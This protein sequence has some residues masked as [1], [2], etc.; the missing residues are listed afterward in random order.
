LISGPR[1]DEVAVEIKRRKHMAR[2]WTRY[3]AVVCVAF[4]LLVGDAQATSMSAD[5]N[6]VDLIRHAEA[7]VMAHVEDVN[8]GFDQNG[9]PHTEVTLAITENIHGDLP[10]HYVFRQYGL[11]QKRLSEDGTKIFMPA[12]ALFPRYSPGEQVMLFLYKPASRT[13]LQTTVALAHG[14]FTIG[15]TRATNA[16]GNTGLFQG[17]GLTT[18]L[19]TPDFA[20]MLDTLTGGV[21]SATLTSFVRR[22]VEEKWI[23]RGFMWKESERR[24]VEDL[25]VPDSDNTHGNVHFSSD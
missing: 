9:M 25:S 22:A 21:S 13:G 11:T 14:K 18:E 5:V 2:R 17:V 16:L 6:L 20:A 10:Q 7:I 3:A 15:G 4:S 19:N 24:N 12:P 1:D 23:S 8:D